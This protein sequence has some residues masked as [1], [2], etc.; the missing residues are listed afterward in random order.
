MRRTTI[1]SNSHGNSANTVDQPR[2]RSSDVSCT[3]KQVSADSTTGHYSLHDVDPRILSVWM[4]WVSVQRASGAALGEP[5]PGCSTFPAVEPDLVLEPPRIW[6]AQT[7][8]QHNILLKSRVIPRLM[9][10]ETTTLMIPK[11]KKTDPSF[12]SFPIWSTCNTG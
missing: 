6:L 3:A 11:V 5:A 9:R 8:S 7:F 2:T 12:V 1:N 10:L 4:G